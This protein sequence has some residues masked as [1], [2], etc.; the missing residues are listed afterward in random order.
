MI[1]SS[2][3]LKNHILKA[4]LNPPEC[5][6]RSMSRIDAGVAEYKAMTMNGIC[7]LKPSDDDIREYVGNILSSYLEEQRNKGNFNPLEG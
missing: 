7:R 2:T 5:G 3:P 4:M 6:M 1:K